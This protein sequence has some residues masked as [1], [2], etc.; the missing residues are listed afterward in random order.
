VLG[1]CAAL[2]ELVG[3]QAQ[4]FQPLRIGQAGRQ[5]MQPVAR[6]HQ[7]LQGRT[8]AQLRGQ[9][10]D[11]VVGQDQPAQRGRQ[12]RARHV[13]NAAGLEAHHLQRRAVTQHPGQAGEGVVG[14]KN[15]LEPVQAWQVVRQAIQLVAREVEHLQRVGQV[16]HFGWQGA[17]PAGQVQAARTGERAAAQLFKGVHA[18]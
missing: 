13:G 16:K 4:Q 1:D 8:P 5:I 14:T 7:F 11:G 10:G 12:G 2:R 3:G 15:H 17:Q 9:A 6:Q 18:R